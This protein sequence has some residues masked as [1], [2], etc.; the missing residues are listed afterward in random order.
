MDIL[1]FVDQSCNTFLSDICLIIASFN[2]TFAPSKF[3]DENL[4]STINEKLMS[5]VTT[6]MGK[7]F[8]CIG[9]RMSFEKNLDETAILV[10]ALDRFHRRLQVKTT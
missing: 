1:E 3:I 8:D 10:R 2:E 5:F 9:R 6:Y 7:F 4:L